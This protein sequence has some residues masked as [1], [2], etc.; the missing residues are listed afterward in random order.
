MSDLGTMLI[1]PLPPSPLSLMDGSYAVGVLPVS[2]G[3]IGALL[4]LP[5]SLP[6]LDASSYRI[7]GTESCPPPYTP[8]SWGQLY[9]RGD[10]QG[11]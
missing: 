4:P 1:L 3:V 10:G 6:L 9:P 7:G 8:P 5:P 11:A 2:A